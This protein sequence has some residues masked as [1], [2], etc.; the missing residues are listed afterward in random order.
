[1]AICEE[2]MQSLLSFTRLWWNSLA[3]QCSIHD[4][5]KHLSNVSNSKVPRASKFEEPSLTSG[6]E[7]FSHAGKTDGQFVLGMEEAAEAGRDKT[8]TALQ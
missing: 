6:P 4:G 1:M 7:F 2:D 5:L 3:M 8:V